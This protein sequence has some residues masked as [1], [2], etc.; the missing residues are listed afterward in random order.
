MRPPQVQCVAMQMQQSRYF[1]WDAFMRGLWEYVRAAARDA[2]RDEQGGQGEGGAK[3]PGAPDVRPLRAA[4]LTR[5]ETEG[6]HALRKCLH[7]NL[8]AQDPVESARLLLFL[9]QQ[10]GPA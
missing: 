3:P 6:L 9:E 5:Q 1:A 7:N 2:A 10:E 8:S 4:L